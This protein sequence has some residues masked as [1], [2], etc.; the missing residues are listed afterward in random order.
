MLQT[1]IHPNLAQPG[2]PVLDDDEDDGSDF[3]P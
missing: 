3:Q 1:M 2:A